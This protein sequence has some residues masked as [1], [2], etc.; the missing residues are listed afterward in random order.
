MLLRP[1]DNC[2]NERPL[3][4]RQ[5]IHIMFV[6]FGTVP[7]F[8]AHPDQN[9]EGGNVPGDQECLSLR[10]NFS[11]NQN[12]VTVHIQSCTVGQTP[13]LHHSCDA[14]SLKFVKG[15]TQMSLF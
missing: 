9:F 10:P 3:C 7:L 11:P 1:D 12:F 4:E 6:I 15:R 8:H 13:L 2:I 14:A 5:N